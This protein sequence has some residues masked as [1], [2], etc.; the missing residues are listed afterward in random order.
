MLRINNRSARSLT[1]KSIKAPSPKKTISKTKP[2]SR[3]PKLLKTRKKVILLTGASAGLGL[4]I[5]KNLINEHQFF[6]VLTAKESSLYRFQKE[7]IHETHRIWIRELDVISQ[8]QIKKLIEEIN[9]K[10][11]GVDILINNA[12]IAGRSTVEDSSRFYRQKQ[13]NVN[14]LAPFDLIS[15]VL[16]PMRRKR[17]GQIINISSAGGF[18]AMPTMS[19]YSASKFALEAASESLWYEMKPWNIHVTLIIPGF[20]DS[21]GFLNTIESRKCKVHSRNSDSIYFE[22]YRNMKNLITAQMNNS[23][24]TNQTIASKIVKTITKADPPLRVF[25]TPDAWLFFWIRKLLP[26]RAYH[27]IIYILLPNIKK[28][29]RN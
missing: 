6:L 29:G 14:Y 28:W 21:I 12:G 26:P 16:S 13:L 19:A 11:G 24:A 7:S 20:I 15:H 3:K 27:F 18:M 8:S 1:N 10:L 23:L 4:A 9:H 22:H 25:V 2:V 5:A 17:F